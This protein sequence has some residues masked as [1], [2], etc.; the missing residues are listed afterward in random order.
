MEAEAEAEAEAAHRGC[1]QPDSVSAATV[2][3]STNLPEIL[4][5]GRQAA[6]GG[7]THFTSALLAFKWPSDAKQAEETPAS[8]R[9]LVSEAAVSKNSL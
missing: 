3:G 9:H 8:E 7:R 1:G 5:G 4:C 6:G 2:P